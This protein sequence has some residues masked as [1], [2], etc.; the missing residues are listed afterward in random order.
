MIKDSA[1]GDRRQF[2][3]ESVGN[4][5]EKALEATEER[6]IQQRY[7]RPPGAL[8]EMA[9]LAACTRCGECVT[10]C[11]PKV[12]RVAPP[13]AGLAAGTPYLEVRRD[14]CLVCTSMPCALACPTDALTVPPNIWEGLRLGVVELVPERCVTFRG[15]VCQ[16]CADACPRGDK[17]LVMDEGG[18]PV[19]RHEGCVA[20]GVCI[21]ACIS[22]PP[23]FEFR[24]DGG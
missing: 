21:R 3:R 20:C 8:T 24:P 2:L 6:M 11:P 18:H 17:A 13:S 23:S 22:V 10:A 1:P 4:L 16:A 19:L 12:I 7:V 15:Q 9:F 5:F 14:P